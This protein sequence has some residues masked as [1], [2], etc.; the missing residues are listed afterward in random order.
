[1]SVLISGY[2][3]YSI[4]KATRNL[5]DLLELHQIADLRDRMLHEIKIVQDDLHLKQTRHA[6][7]LAELVS[8]VSKMTGTIDT[9]F[10]CHHREDVVNRLTK[11]HEDTEIYKTALSRVYTLR[12]NS[13]RLKREEDEAF[14]VGEELIGKVEAMLDFTN[15]NLERKTKVILKSVNRSK[16]L[17]LVLTVI[18][19]FVVF[20]MVLWF[21]LNFT[22]PVSALLDATGR[23]K[24][25]DFDYRVGKLDDEFGEV[26]Q[27]FN[28][29]A[30]SL[31]EMM[32]TMLRAEQMVLMG[33]MA[34][35]LAHEIKNPITGIKLAAEVVRDEANLEGEYKEMCTKTIDQIHNIEKLM[36]SLLSYAKPP[37]SYAEMQN[38]NRI[39]ETAFSTVEIIVRKRSG[40]GEGGGNI[41]MA[42]ELDPDLP[43]VM[44]DATHVQ[45]I[46]LNLML[47]AV[48]A[49]Y[50]GGTLT[51]RSSM[52]ADGDW[53]QVDVS[54]T[55][56]GIS[57]SLGEEIFQPFF[58]TK[59]KGTGLG[60]A[61]VRRLVEINK[62][63]VFFRSEV[64]IG[65]TF[66]VRFPLETG[67]E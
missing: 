28:E 50:Q 27:S 44:T 14:K 11:L 21:Y 33:E 32:R 60:L 62:G 65:S 66:T 55:G 64:G 54:D 3:I 1:M 16:N 63:E 56:I 29:M 51:V 13:Q 59:V 20:G 58:S 37:M 10:G 34:S 36:K 39:I 26:A 49:M 42:M 47:N 25:G 5:G 31:K 4:E 61:T 43:E 19:P 18:A 9:C 2:V 17:L 67:K 7:D 6:R 40:A 46:L 8:H 22:R 38:I 57:P 35:R 45:Q 12:A 24:K 23:L 48:D 15:R 41:Q 30:E 53:L 52:T